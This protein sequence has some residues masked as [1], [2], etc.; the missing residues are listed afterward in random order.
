MHDHPRSSN[1]QEVRFLLGVL[2]LEYERRTVPAG[3]VAG[4]SGIPA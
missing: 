3:P 2:G 1:A 4:A